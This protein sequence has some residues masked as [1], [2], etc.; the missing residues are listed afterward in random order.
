M[1]GI[2]GI[3]M[4]EGQ[5]ERARVERMIRSLQYRGP[6]GSGIF[7]EGPAVI[8]H[9]RLSIIDLSEAASQPMH[10]HDGRYVMVY[11]GELYNFR[12]LA[13]QHRLTL[14]THSDSEVL[15][16]LFALYG[17][18]VLNECNG[19][20]AAAV[21]DRKE[22]GLS[23][24]RDRLGIKPLFLYEKDG[25]LAFASELKAL[26]MAGFANEWDASALTSYL[27]LGYIPAPASAYR[28]I[29]KFPQGQ[30]G[31]WHAGTM[32][33]EAYWTLEEA[34][35]GPVL[36]NFEETKAEYKRLLEDSV[37][38]R[39][40]SDVPLGAFLSGG[41]DSSL[42][43]AV[44]QKISGEPIRT[45]S[46]GFDDPKHDESA[47]AAAIARHLGTR[48]REF[49]VSSRDAMEWI[50]EVIDLFDEPFADSSFIPTSLISRLAREEVTV[51]L[52]GDGGD[53]LFHGYGMYRWAERLH[54]PWM[55]YGHR[56]LSRILRHLPDRYQRVG[57]LLDYKKSDSFEQH[58]FSQE[59]YLFSAQEIR[60]LS[61][62]LPS[63]PTLPI[64]RIPS[65]ALTP[66]ERQALF[67]LKY[68]LP[69]DLLTK[70]DRSSMRHSLELRVPL[71]DH[72]L[73]ALALR[74]D[75]ALKMK[76]GQLK[77]FLKEVL[78]DYLPR[79]LFDRPKRGFSIPLRSW[80][81]GDLRYLQE[82]YLSE[83][84]LRNTAL[85]DPSVVARLRHRFQQGESYLYNRIWSLIVL[86]IFLMNKANQ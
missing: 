9:R 72:R 53:E 6:D 1:C 73:V 26:E 35:R 65:R 49:R 57:A 39:M 37:S 34:G 56:P 41:V 85:L 24:F 59:Q 82:E 51:A 13:R 68:Y 3:V 76:N 7:A 71:L 67:D 38:A 66:A 14:R 81:S 47:Y 17:K 60:R 33:K 83:E 84:A 64:P 29:G 43:T 69:D 11:N 20:F 25:V 27:H 16:E 79:P 63:L 74:I 10:S 77:Y 21:W 31:I 28:H 19:M 62:D 80:L 52:S 36:R 70:V 30:I 86:Q 22:Q 4:R 58:L 5:P 32:K 42:V 78:A 48:H 23:L 18:E 44:A 46:I 15:L 12:E 45:F 75:P 54:R 8:G 50:P 40:I 55:K 2:A 61:P